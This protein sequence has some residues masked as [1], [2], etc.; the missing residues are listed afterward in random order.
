MLCKHRQQTINKST[1]CTIHPFCISLSTIAVYYILK[2]IDLF[3]LLCYDHFINL[4]VYLSSHN[5]NSRTK[6]SIT[7]EHFKPSKH[8]IYF[9]YIQIKFVYNRHAQYTTII[10]LF[11][12]SACTECR[13]LCYQQ[14]LNMN[15]TYIPS[16]FFIGCICI[17]IFA[18]TNSSDEKSKKKKI[19]MSLSVIKETFFSVVSLPLFTCQTNFHQI[20]I[21]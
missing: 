11:F 1:N 14:Q 4:S 18:I 9:S 12:F 20:V 13:L 6:E 7:V 2:H 17:Y 21:L 19:F 10:Y 15:S 5:Y 3:R 16:H 8:Q